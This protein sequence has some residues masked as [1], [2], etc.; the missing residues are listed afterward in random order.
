ML[1]GCRTGQVQGGIQGRISEIDLGLVYFRDARDAAGK[2]TVSNWAGAVPCGRP[3]GARRRKHQRH[4]ASAPKVTHD[5][6]SHAPAAE[7]EPRMEQD[8]PLSGWPASLADLPAHL[9]AP[10]EGVGD[11][12]A[13]QAPCGG[14]AKGGTRPRKAASS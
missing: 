6:P 11:I 10:G 2:L 14:G 9:A 1:M 5:R 3:A 7:V 4:A 12:A 13:S 8:V